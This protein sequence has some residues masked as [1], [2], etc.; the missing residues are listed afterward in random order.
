MVM[1]METVDDL[2]RVKNREFIKRDYYEGEEK[3]KPYLFS[4]LEQ[5]PLFSEIGGRHLIRFT[6]SIHDEDG[7]ITGDPLKIDK[8]LRHL[9]AK[10]EEN[11]E[12]ITFIEDDLQEGSEIAIL[13]YGMC[14]RISREVIRRERKK[15][16]RISLFTIYSLYPFPAG[17]LRQMLSGYEKIIVPELNIGLYVKEVERIVKDNQKLV[18][19]TRVDGRLLTPSEIIEKGE[20][21]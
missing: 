10:I 18:S 11:I 6:T 7:I 3:F 12:E 4:K 21:G 1:N 8:K 2:Q 20:L 19:I 9:K 16:K 13:A 14:A 17:R 15:G 5:V